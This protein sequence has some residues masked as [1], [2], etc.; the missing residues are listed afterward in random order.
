MQKFALTLLTF[1]AAL[2]VAACGGMS[3]SPSSPVANAPFLRQLSGSSPIKH[4]VIVIQENRTFNDLFA[5][6]PGATGTTVGKKRVGNQTKS[7]TLKEVNLAGQRNLN[8]G[9]HGWVT[10][11]D[12]GK[13]DGFN[14]VR[15]PSNNKPEGATPYEYVNPSQI[16]PY[17]TMAQQYGLADEMFTTQGSASFTAHQ[18]LIRG[19]T[20]IDSSHSLIDNPPYGNAWGCDSA[21]GT[22]TS[23][24]TTGLQYER[25]AGPFPCTSHFPGSGAGYQTLRDLLDA[26]SVSWKYYTPKVGDNG[27][28]WNAFDVISPV[29]Q[30]PEWGTNVTWPETNIFNDISNGQLA[31]VSW[32]VPDGANSDHPNKGSDAGPSWVAS[33]VDAIG[34]SDYWDS[35]A[36]IVVWDDWGGFYDSVEPP[37]LD[38]QG[39]P[40]FRVPMILV[41]P[42]ARETSSSQPG[43]ISHTVYAFGSIVRFVEDTFNLGRLGTTDGTSNSMDDMFDFYQTPRPFQII[44]SKYT[45]SYFL[46]RKPS[47]LPVDTE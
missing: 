2:S 27:A 30:G 3:A 21:P 20:A 22:T 47:G 6:F 33:V 28:I 10:A 44:G 1:P 42:Y 18:D 43:Y 19:G 5:T 31:T 9:Y 29:R 14:E 36:I 26:K 16:A 41:S 8:H 38:N 15:Y 7:I 4:I 24:I 35:A 45:R 25:N 46:H 13:M 40:G 37:P 39:G 11:Y 32:V 23:L 12:G 34:E 17:W